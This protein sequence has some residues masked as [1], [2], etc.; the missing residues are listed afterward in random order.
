MEVVT[1]KYGQPWWY[2]SRKDV[3]G[4]LKRAALSTNGIGTTPILELDTQVERVDLESRKVYVK[5]G[6]TFQ[7]DVIIGA[8]G[9]R[10]ASG[11]SVF[12]KLQTETQGL[13]AYRCMVPSDRLRNDPNMRVF[14]DSAKV[15]MIIGPDRR[16]VAYPCSSWDYINFVCIFPDTTERHIQWNNKVGVE[17]MVSVFA[18][19]HPSVTT[20]LAMASDTG[21][22]QLRDR[23]PLPALAKGEFA[24]V[25]DAAHAMGPRKVTFLFIL[26]LL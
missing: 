4:E 8:D 9:I 23:K 12:G 5:D 22:W 10:S 14:I 19:F 16:I 18:D 24:L 13:S 3:H 17:E 2:F 7:G 1:K 20:A 25:G 21:V 6:R 11:N 15:V 26:I